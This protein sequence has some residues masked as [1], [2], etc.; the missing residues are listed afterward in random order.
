[1]DLGNMRRSGVRGFAVHCL[2]PKCRHQ[3]V[4][5][6]D[7]YPDEVEVP[8]FQLRMAANAAAKM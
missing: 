2:N 7:D 4:F 3:A 5:S 8:S 1:M 6:A